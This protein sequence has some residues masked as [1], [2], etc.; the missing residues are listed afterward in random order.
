MLSAGMTLLRMSIGSLPL[1]NV[2]IM[3]L[4]DNLYGTSPL[5][6]RLG[7]QDVETSE[8]SE[9]NAEMYWSLCAVLS[10]REGGK[11]FTNTAL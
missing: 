3:Y 9:L 5:K 11:G 10:R 4:E 7:N 6:L 2:T 1:S 8:T